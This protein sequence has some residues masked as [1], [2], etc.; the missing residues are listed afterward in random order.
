MNHI[1]FLLEKD[2]TNKQKMQSR[3]REAKVNSENK[4]YYVMSQLY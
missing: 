1:V 4:T 3:E 2:K